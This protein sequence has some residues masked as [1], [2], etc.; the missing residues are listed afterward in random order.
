MP[1]LNATVGRKLTRAACRGRSAA[2]VL[3]GL[4]L[5]ACADRPDFPS[6]GDVPEAPPVPSLEE[7]RA[8]AEDLAQDREDFDKPDVLR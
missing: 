3:A 1:E 2:L 7:R 5:A 4:F 8:T 6:L